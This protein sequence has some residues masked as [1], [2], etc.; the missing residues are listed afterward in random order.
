M[1]F[2][3]PPGTDRGPLR[4]TLGADVTDTSSAL[5]W[6]SHL[7]GHASLREYDTRVEVAGDRI[8]ALYSH[9]DPYGIAV[10]WLVGPMPLLPPAPVTATRARLDMVVTASGT[11][12]AIAADG[13]AAGRL[14]HYRADFSGRRIAYDGVPDPDEWPACEL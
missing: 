4:F 1:V 12:G 13:T 9:P 3:P 8:T 2:R 7:D 11:T 10:T 6:M 14:L 5:V